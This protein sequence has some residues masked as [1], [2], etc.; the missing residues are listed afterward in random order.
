MSSS[1]SG[2]PQQ[3]RIQEAFSAIPLCTLSITILCVVL[4]ILASVLGWDIGLFA[5][6]AG[7]VVYAHQVRHLWLHA[8]PQPCDQ[9]IACRMRLSGPSRLH[10]L[11]VLQALDL[12][13]LPL[14]HPAHRHEHDELACDRELAGELHSCRLMQSRFKYWGSALYP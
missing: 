10:G 8:H 12:C 7:G 6:S 2:A 1:S 9:R 14:R 13:L 11:P 5:I 4:H 3:S